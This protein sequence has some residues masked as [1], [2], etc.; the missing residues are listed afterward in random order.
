MMPTK[1]TQMMNALFPPPLLA[2]GSM[3]M[4][5]HRPNHLLFH[6]QLPNPIQ[7]YL[8]LF[9]LLHPSFFSNHVHLHELVL[10]AS[11]S[12][13]PRPIMWSYMMDERIYLYTIW[14]KIHS[15]IGMKSSFSSCGC[16]MLAITMHPCRIFGL[17][18]LHNK[19]CRAGPLGSQWVVRH[20]LGQGCPLI[21]PYPAR[22]THFQQPLL[23]PLLLFISPHWS[24]YH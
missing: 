11:P 2:K 12:Y 18:H 19:A 14:M 17:E 21:A 3:L 9:L 1:K 16:I 13:L 22:P 8:N 4:M 7:L 23:R 20:F 10:L 6:H 5:I 24:S 15:Q